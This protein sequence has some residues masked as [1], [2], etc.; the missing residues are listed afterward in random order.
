MKGKEH[1]HVA[2]GTW[3]KLCN[4]LANALWRRSP[5]ITPGK[6]KQKAKTYRRLS[7]N[8]VNV[9]PTYLLQQHGFKFKL[10]QRSVSS[11]CV[12]PTGQA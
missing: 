12:E 7:Y 3:G 10:A 8:Y 1:G 2:R 4:Y 5:L 11:H 9:S 6:I